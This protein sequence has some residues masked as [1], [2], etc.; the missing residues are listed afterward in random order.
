M[1]SADKRV[2]VLKQFKRTYIEITNTCNLSCAFCPGTSR[3]V[4]FLSV[5]QFDEILAR[6]G[7]YSKHIYFHVLGE[8]LL[9][10]ELGKLLDTAQSHGKPVNLVTN[11]TLIENIGDVLVSK[12]ALRQ[13]TFSMHSLMAKNNPNVPETSPTHPF[14]PS[15]SREG[16][17]DASCAVAELLRS[18]EGRGELKIK[19]I[20]QKSEPIE[21]ESLVQEYFEPILRFTRKA[22]TAQHDH[23]I[24]YRLWPQNE[25]TNAAARTE[26]LARIEKAFSLTFSL[27]EKLKTTSAVPLDKNVFLNQSR[28]FDWPDLNGPDFGAHGFCLGL[29]EQFAII[30]NGTVV[31]CCLD[32]NADMALGNIFKQPIEEILGSER[33]RRIV[34]GFSQRRVVEKLCRRCFYRKRF[35]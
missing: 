11:G 7:D 20:F 8:P 14:V 33:A 24:C 32:R 21:I 16:K 12:P 3:P 13:I 1:A 10:P 22:R 29:R 18:V 6:L 23:F 15:L 34:E 19:P 25:S 17:P 5:A 27:S 35:G 2:T 28:H 9:H 26:L 4:Q 30:V 31:P